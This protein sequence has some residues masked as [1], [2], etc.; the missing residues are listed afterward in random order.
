MEDIL[1]NTLFEVDAVPLPVMSVNFICQN[2]Y[3]LSARSSATSANSSTCI[4]LT[5]NSGMG[6]IPSPK[7]NGACEDP[8]SSP[9]WLCGRN[10]GRSLG[11]GG[12]PDGLAAAP[13]SL[14]SYT[15]KSI[16]GGVSAEHNQNAFTDRDI[17]Y[18]TL[19]V[20]AYIPFLSGLV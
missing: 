6:G 2:N 3:W 1:C 20:C 13:P 15:D 7:I 10:M 18:M 14:R 4:F 12:V 19:P 8:F 9:D 16:T 11:I 17:S 5:T